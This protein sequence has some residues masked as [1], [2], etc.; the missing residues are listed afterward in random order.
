RL[1]G[2][3]TLEQRPLDINAIARRREELVA[4]RERL[5][6][7]VDALHARREPW[8]AS[9]YDALQGL[10]RL[11]A[12]RPAPQTTVRLVPEVASLLVGDR[13][14]QVAGE[15]VRAAELGAFEIQP[16]STPWYGADLDSDDA[17]QDVLVRLGRLLESGLPGLQRRA[18][19]VADQT[20]LTTA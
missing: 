11:T 4:R 12:P 1:L 9:A 3:M 5:R 20:G 6:G 7:Y 10:A 17:A 18:S 14:S 19:E 16:N 8:G 13:R 2:A 15:L